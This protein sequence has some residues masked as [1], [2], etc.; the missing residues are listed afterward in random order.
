MPERTYSQKVARVFEIVDYF[1][2]VPAGIGGLVGL[3]MIQHRPFY[4]LLL[5]GF[6]IAGIVLMVGYFKHSRG[7][8]DERRFSA[9][10]I[11]SAVYN[12][13]LLLPVLYFAAT[14]LQKESF[15]DF[16][17]RI[18]GG[19]IVFF[20]F[21]VSIVFSYVAAVISSLKAYSH[22]ERKNISNSRISPINP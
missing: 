19:K 9:L 4:A 10:W 1:M 17:G 2:L 8:L 14:L 21:I 3:A 12:F 11:T 18:D 13:L 7:T 22:R 15:R 20:L 5:F 6:L 16:N